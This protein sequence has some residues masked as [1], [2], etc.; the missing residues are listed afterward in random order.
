MDDLGYYEQ[1]KALKEKAVIASE[2]KMTHYEPETGNEIM[3][4]ANEEQ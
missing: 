4:S 1:W 3:E 2:D